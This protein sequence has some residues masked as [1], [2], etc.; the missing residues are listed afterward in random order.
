MDDLD[1]ILTPRASA[2]PPTDAVWLVTARAVA[3]RRW[4][5][6]IR[7]SLALAMSFAVGMVV[8]LFVRPAPVGR[9]EQ[10]I[11]AVDPPP[12][13]DEPSADPYENDPPG[14][15]ERWAGVAEGEKR[16]T[17]FR[18]AGDGFLK[19]GDESAAL[20]CYRR[21]LDGGTREE[22]AIRVEDTWLLMTLKMA[23][24]RE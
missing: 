18:R 6:R 11:A 19:L 14:R 16:R 1:A 17:L 5:R 12:K 13:S 4:G 9:Q 2:T 10:P 8:M 22:L 21:A 7:N 20:R 24:S 15:V 23:R 3:R